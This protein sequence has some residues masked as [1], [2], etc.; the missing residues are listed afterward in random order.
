MNIVTPDEGWAEI[1]L[2]WAEWSWIY[3]YQ[4]KIELNI[5]IPGWLEIILDEILSVTLNGKLS[6]IC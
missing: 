6:R 3:L 5:I 2:D 4:A 1:G